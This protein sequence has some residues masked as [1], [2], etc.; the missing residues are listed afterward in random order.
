MSFLI[1]DEERFFDFDVLASQGYPA[2]ARPAPRQAAG[3][4]GGL[5]IESGQA[6]SKMVRDIFVIR[7]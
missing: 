2:P 4:A 7:T 5:Y 1:R 6:I 3:Q